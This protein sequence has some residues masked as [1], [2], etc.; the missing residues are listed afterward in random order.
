MSSPPP[1]PLNRISSYQPQSSSSNPQSSSLLPRTSSHSPSPSLSSSSSPA[2]PQPAQIPDSPPA[3][4]PLPLSASL[5][6]T[7]LPQDASTALAKAVADLDGGGDDGMPSKV[8]IRLQPIGA[9]PQLRQR[10]FRV[11]A[12]NRFETVVMYLRRKLG[13][14]S[15]PGTARG[16]QSVFCYVNNIFA[17]GLDEGVG[18]LWRCF[19]TDDQLIVGYS[20]TPAFG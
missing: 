13:A 10:V 16:A 19:K 15:G 1:P 8:T 4:L 5:V 12:S 2:P 14:E 18:G 20:I 7:A 17:P 11:S 9:A 6:L 3:T